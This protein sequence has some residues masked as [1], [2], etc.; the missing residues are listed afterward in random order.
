MLILF[1]F[2]QTEGLP[3]L[4]AEVHNVLD[5]RTLYMGEKFYG[6]PLKPHADIKTIYSHFNS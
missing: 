4:K 1:T 2:Y 6:L 5:L 3:F